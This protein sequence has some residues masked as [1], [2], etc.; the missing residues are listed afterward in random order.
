MNVDE[1]AWWSV[2]ITAGAGFLGATMGAIVHPLINHQTQK[3]QRKTAWKREALL[4]RLNELYQPLYVDFV[5]MPDKDPEHYFVD[6]TAD[7]FNEWLNNVLKI[8]I[9]KIHLV[10]DEVRDKVNY[11]IEIASRKD[12]DAESEVRQLY[13]HIKKYFIILRKKLGLHHQ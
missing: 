2:I 11:C 7:D 1:I 10:P 9:P 3:W 13:D 5:V 4:E 12:Y 6:W 8:I